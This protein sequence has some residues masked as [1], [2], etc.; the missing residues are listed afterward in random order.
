[1]LSRIHFTLINLYFLNFKSEKIISY[2][3]WYFFEDQKDYVV[4]M[5]KKKRKIIM[6]M[7]SQTNIHTKMK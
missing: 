6:I 1:M 4:E 7:T 3:L 5:Q 2:F